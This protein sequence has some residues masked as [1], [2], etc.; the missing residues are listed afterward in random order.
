MNATWLKK[1][2]KRPKALVPATYSVN[3]REEI[4]R[5]DLS[6]EDFCRLYVS[7]ILELS[8]GSTLESFEPPDHFVVAIPNREPQ[9]VFF[10]NIW[11]NYRSDPK[12]RLEAIERASRIFSSPTNGPGTFPDRASIVPLIK[13]EVYLSVARNKETGEVPFAHQ[14]LAG[15][16]WIV[17]AVDTPD[18]MRTLGTA[19]MKGMHLDPPQMK[20]LAVENLQRILPPVERHGDGPV[21]LLTAGADYVASLL[22]FDY[23]WE[24]MEELMTGDIVAAVPSRDVLLFTD[25]TSKE[26]L[27]QMRASIT[28]I[29]NSAGYLVSGT[30]LRRNNGKWSVFS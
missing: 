27:E 16:L 18:A 19:E 30:M 20:D 24:Q 22:L 23:V 3:W 10:E 15:D 7:A 12:G 1:F 13:D 21:Y 28:E 8:P 25:S 6:R 2:F 4:S 11:R 26:G 29:L 17:Y 14:H 9:T 5:E